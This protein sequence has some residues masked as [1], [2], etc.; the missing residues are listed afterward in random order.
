MLGSAAFLQNIGNSV[1]PEDKTKI[2]EEILLIHPLKG[3]KLYE[4]RMLAL[5][6]ELQSPK[7]SV[8]NLSSTFEE[9]HIMLPP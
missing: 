4:L 8:K 7:I 2:G 5:I 3:L 6:T 9:S 1:S